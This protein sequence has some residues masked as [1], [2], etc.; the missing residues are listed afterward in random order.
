MN[1]KSVV[2]FASKQDQNKPV[3]FELTL[4]LIWVQIGFWK[5]NNWVPNQ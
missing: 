5:E 3:W 2:M 1:L 4:N